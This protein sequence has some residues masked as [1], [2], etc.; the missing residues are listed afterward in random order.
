MRILIVS[1]GYPPNKA[2]GAEL[3]AERTARGL[4]A[5]GHDV[6]VIAVES[7]Q[8]T[9]RDFEWV[10][11]VQDGVYVRRLFYDLGSNP[12][13]FRASYDHPQLT[14]AIEDLVI[15]WM[16]DLLHVFSGYL[17]GKSTARVAET[18]RK[19][20]VVSLTD[21]W[22]LCHRINL[23]RSNGERCTT[24]TPAACARCH[25]ETQRRFRVPAQLAPTLA[26]NFWSL[27]EHASVLGNAVGTSQQTRRENELIPALQS[28]DALL[29]P[30][31]YLA[32]VY[33]EAGVDPSRV[34]VSRQ[35]VD[36][37][38]CLLRRPSA[39]LRV[40]YMGQVKAH[41][42]V[43]LLVEAW[44]ILS[45]DRPR[46]LVVYGSDAG[47][48]GY[49]AMLRDKLAQFDN[50]AWPGAFKRPEVWQIL[51]EMDV[52]VVPSRWVENSPNTILEAQA[53]G[54]PIVGSNLGGVAEMVQH[55]GNGLVFAVDDAQDLARQLQRLLD[56]PELLDR[57][58][59][60]PMSFKNMETSL[61]ETIDVYEAVLEGPRRTRVVSKPQRNSRRQILKQAA[62]GWAAAWT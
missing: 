38:T 57:L 5:R 11:Q 24:R 13:P 55:E 2:A 40:G 50:V 58:R 61:D 31:Q 48:P 14:Q 20:L 25:A 3:R 30:S 45:G 43:D 18:H 47:E 62:L 49:G 42:G 8:H 36:V 46:S 1:H 26:D 51:S 7:T 59:R 29:A 10:D 35:G 19:P 56:E 52:L 12:D 27:A 44:G 16:P 15:T 39:T 4:I 17:T 37:A 9:S 23:V 34:H 22:W 21:Y 32:D 33:I 54:V 41:K 6:A 60:S 28:A 53:V